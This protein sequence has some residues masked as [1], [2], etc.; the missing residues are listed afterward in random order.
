MSIH[1]VR[2]GGGGK[3]EIFG[4]QVGQR[5][6]MNC[7]L[8]C[9]FLR[10]LLSSDRQELTADNVN[11]SCSIFHIIFKT[12]ERLAQTFHKCSK[13]STILVKLN[14]HACHFSLVTHDK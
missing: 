10:V 2:N 3:K 7:L 1:K 13:S 8:L 6:Y 12:Y 11:V 9:I 4:K 14:K 5:S